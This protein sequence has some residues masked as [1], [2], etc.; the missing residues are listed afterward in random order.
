MV[1]AASCRNIVASCVSASV[2]VN[3]ADQVYQFDGHHA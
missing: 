3:R 2:T 1:E